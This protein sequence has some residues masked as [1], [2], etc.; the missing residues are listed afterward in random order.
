VSPHKDRIA[1]MVDYPY[2]RRAFL[3]ASA[4]AVIWI[5]LRASRRSNPM[6]FLTG[7]RFQMPNHGMSAQHQQPSQID[8]PTF[9]DSS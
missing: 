9:A 6:W 4:I 5:F 3:F 8:I 7:C 2:S 1:D